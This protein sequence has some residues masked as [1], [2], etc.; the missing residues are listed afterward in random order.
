[1]MAMNNNPEASWAA[2]MVPTYAARRRRIVTKAAPSSTVAPADG[3]GTTS[4]PWGASW[5]VVSGAG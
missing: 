4:W 1:M 2:P 3:S 5:A